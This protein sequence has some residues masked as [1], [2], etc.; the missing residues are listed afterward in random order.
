MEEAYDQFNY[1]IVDDF[2]QMRVSLRGM[3]GSFGAERITICSTGEEGLKHLSSATYDVVIC[4]YNLGEGR[5]GQ[6]LLEEARYQG[7]L[8][9][10]SIFFMVTAESS[11]PFVL[12][13][14]EQQPDEYMV[15]PLNQEALH[16]RLEIAIQRKRELLPVDSALAENDIEG[17]IKY[18]AE[19]RG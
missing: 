17:A 10:A 5:D 13:A 8:K 9:H 7:Y 14:L 12:G 1:L 19:N 3:L 2:E 18:C 11:M 6:Q 4:D 16:H 15:K